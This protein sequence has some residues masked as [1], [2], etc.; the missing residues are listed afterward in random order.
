[1]SEKPEVTLRSTKVE[2]STELLNNLIE[3]PEKGTCLD[4][5]KESLNDIKK[6][7][8]LSIEKIIDNTLISNQQIQTTY[9]IYSFDE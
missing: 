4:F 6:E 2:K 3:N 7:K 5:M 8:I 9:K 1:M